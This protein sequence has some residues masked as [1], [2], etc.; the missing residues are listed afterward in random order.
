MAGFAEVL[1]RFLPAEEGGRRTGVC[2]STEVTPHYRPHLRV[3]DGDGEML[4]VEFVDGPDDPVQ[5]GATTYA[6]V[7]FEFEP[8][9]C[10]DALVAGAKFQ[11]LEGSRIV[12]IGEVTRR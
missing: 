5:P 11:V 2:L 4:G 8:A 1:I 12:G 3:V 7:Q 10:Y 9:V 6:T